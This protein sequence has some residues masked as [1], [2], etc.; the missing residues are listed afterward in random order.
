MVMDDAANTMTYSSDGSRKV[1]QLYGALNVDAEGYITMPVKDVLG[2]LDQ[3][4]FL[5]TNWKAADEKA[6]YFE[7]QHAKI[8]AELE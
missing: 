5:R 8:N 3:M 7:Q 2:V 6:I 4:E 1:M